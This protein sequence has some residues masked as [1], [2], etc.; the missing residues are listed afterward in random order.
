MRRAGAIACLV[1][2]GQASLA[3]SGEDPPEFP[4]PSADVPPLD[5]E[6]IEEW[7]TGSP[8]EAWT[9]EPAL[10]PPRDPSPHGDARICQN[11]ILT[12]AGADDAFPI[13]AASVKQQGSGDVVQLINV[14]VRGSSD[15]GGQAW[16]WWRKDVNLETVLVDAYGAGECTDCHQVAARDFVFTIL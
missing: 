13:G 14:V 9:C 2:C 12:G 3:C 11:A 6:A 15:Q 10:R 16:Y 8:Y 1:L 4:G 5:S 7:L